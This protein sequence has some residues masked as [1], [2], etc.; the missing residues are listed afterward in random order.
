MQNQDRRMQ[1]QRHPLLSL[2]VSTLGGGLTWVV[3]LQVLKFTVSALSIPMI[4]TDRVYRVRAAC[5]VLLPRTE[6]SR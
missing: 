2:L 1:N 4:A 6:V 3:Y 5:P